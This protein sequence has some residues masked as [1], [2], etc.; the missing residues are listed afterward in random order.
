[1][2]GKRNGVREADPSHAPARSSGAVRDDGVG[3]TEEA[4]DGARREA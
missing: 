3:T 2:T 4:E 1:M